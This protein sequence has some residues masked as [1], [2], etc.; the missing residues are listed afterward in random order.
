[1]RT[2]LFSQMNQEAV[3][4]CAKFLPRALDEATAEGCLAP[5]MW[6]TDASSTD[7][8]LVIY[9]AKALLYR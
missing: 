8:E 9:Y 2:Y 5:D 4:L 6:E 3:A 7:C 1:M